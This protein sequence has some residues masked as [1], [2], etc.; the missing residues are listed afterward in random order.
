MSRVLKFILAPILIVL[1]VLAFVYP[2]LMVG[3]GKLI[4]GHQSLESDC[5][6]CHAPLLGADSGRCVSCHKPA[7][8]GRLTTTGKAIVK[9]LT[10]SPVSYTHLDVYKRQ[11]LVLGCAAGA[12]SL[13]ILRCPSQSRVG[14]AGASRR[15]GQGA[16]EFPLVALF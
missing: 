2:H 5:F 14:H 3:P 11:E 12:R 9:P 10:A 6:A 8:I 1:A 13:A 4:P 7:E 16:S 15:T